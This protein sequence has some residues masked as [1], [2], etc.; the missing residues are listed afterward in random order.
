MSEISELVFN[1]KYK[2]FQVLTFGWIAWIIFIVGVLV[3][4]MSLFALLSHY[5]IIKY[6]FIEKFLFMKQYL[7]LVM[8]QNTAFVKFWVYEILHEYN[9]SKT[10]YII[11]AIIAILLI[12][13]YIIM[14]S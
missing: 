3:L 11:C 10:I 12:V 13:A 9:K 1:I 8:I 7:Y 6:S 2:M 5:K 4:F 14:K